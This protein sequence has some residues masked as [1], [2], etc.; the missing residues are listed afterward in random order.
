MNIKRIIF[1][2]TLIS[3]L[4]SAQE[5]SKFY[6]S[7]ELGLANIAFAKNHFFALRGENLPFK[8]KKNLDTDSNNAKGNSVAITFGT[9]LPITFAGANS[10]KI[11]SKVWHITA[12]ASNTKNFK[13]NGVGKKYGW[14]ELDN[15]NGFRTNTGNTLNTNIEQKLRHWGADILLS[16]EYA[17]GDDASLSIFTGPSYRS[18]NQ[19]TDIKGNIIGGSI[20]VHLKDKISENLFGAK[21]GINYNLKFKNKWLLNMD[22]AISQYRKFATY[23]GAYTRYS[24]PFSTSV[25]RKLSDT[26]NSKGVD[27]DIQLGYKFAKQTYVSIYADYNY[28]SNVTQVSYGSGPTDPAGGV[29]SLS[30]DEQSS[31]VYGL[32]LNY[33]F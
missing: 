18:N 33:M 1:I 13:D 17:L 3:T 5:N 11:Y 22:F 15:S 32:R 23:T 30:N 6:A 16:F 29:L 25:N 19:D 31:L 14:V 24:F 2:I 12:Q 21:L 26:Q 10:I 28:L 8:R 7:L 20:T 27:L 9:H 4:L